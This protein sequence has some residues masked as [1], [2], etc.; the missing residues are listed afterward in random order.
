F[1][2]VDPATQQQSSEEKK[3]N[4]RKQAEE[5]KARLGRGED[6]FQLCKQF[7]DEPWAKDESAADEPLYVKGQMPPEFDAVAFSIKTNTFS[8]IVESALGYHIIRVS[9][10]QPATRLP[11]AEVAPRLRDFLIEEGVKKRLPDYLASLKK[12]AAV[13][14]VA[15]VAEA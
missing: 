15:K 2:T 11:L 9:E 6:F 8:G 12:D 13:E 4:K 7:S 14:I 1:L 10:R 3:A 5:V